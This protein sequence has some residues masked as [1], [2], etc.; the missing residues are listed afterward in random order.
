[1]KMVPKEVWI[2][3]SFNKPGMNL[4]SRAL[5]AAAVR[6][7]VIANNIAN[8]DTPNFKRSAVRFEELLQ[9]KLDGQ[10]PLQG[11][12]TDRRHF[13]IGRGSTEIGPEVVK[14]EYSVIN[15][16]MNNVDID[17]EMALMAKNQLRYNVLAQQMS[18][19]LKK[20][21]TAMDGRR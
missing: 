7:Q 3:F 21:R 19:E 20:I 18:A 14:D 9:Q 4:M 10:K 12:R 6:Q 1:M 17:Y 8:V 11:Y 16:N 2:M 5:D 15:N 13:Y